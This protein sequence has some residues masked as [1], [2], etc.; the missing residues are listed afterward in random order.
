M[1]QITLTKLVNDRP[2]LADRLRAHAQMQGVSHLVV[3]QN[4]T[5]DSSHLGDETILAIGPKMT[6]KTL[7][8]IEGRHLHD[9]PSQRQYPQ[10]YVDL[11]NPNEGED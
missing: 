10:A 3:F 7:A 8:E 11:A 6:Y 4:V 9:L 1:Q 5:L 2:H